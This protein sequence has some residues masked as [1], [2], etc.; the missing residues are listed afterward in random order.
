VI[1][2]FDHATNV[3]NHLPIVSSAAPRQSKETPLTF[4]LSHFSL[5]CARF[6]ELRYAAR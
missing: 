1:I 3:A 2:S 6:C 5:S 4:A